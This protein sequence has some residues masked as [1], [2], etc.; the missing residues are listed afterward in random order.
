V[1]FNWKKSFEHKKNEKLENM[2]LA[3]SLPTIV[4]VELSPH[5]YLLVNAASGS[6]EILASDRGWRLGTSVLP[7]IR[8]N[9]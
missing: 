2:I 6:A 3:E 7:E 9:N 5:V 4:D 1:L 8:K